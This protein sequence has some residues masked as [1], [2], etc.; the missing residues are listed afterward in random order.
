MRER[1]TVYISD[2]ESGE[3]LSVKWICKLVSGFLC[4]I[5]C[6]KRSSLNLR[7]A[8]IARHVTKVGQ[9]PRTCHD[10]SFFLSFFLS[11]INRKYC[12]LQDKQKV[13]SRNPLRSIQSCWFIMNKTKRETTTHGLTLT[14]IKAEVWSR[15]SFIDFLNRRRRSSFERV[16]HA[17]Q[18][19]FTVRKPN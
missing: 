15:S 19:R 14:S 4:G 8:E 7:K 5:R 1:L 16:S 18:R 10:F 11:F 17:G 6:N 2:R 13:S 3:S 12:L 9:V